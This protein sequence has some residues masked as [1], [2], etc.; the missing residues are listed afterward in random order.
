MKL[1]QDKRRLV[2]RRQLLTGAAATAV[3]AP[4]VPL[5]EGEAQEAGT[6][7]L[8]TWYTPNGTIHREWTPTGSAQNFTLGRILEPLEEMK[9]KIVVVSGLRHNGSKPGTNHFMGP[10]L[11][12]SGSTLNELSSRVYWGKSMSIDQAYAQHVGEVTPFSSLV[13]GV[14]SRQGDVRDRTSYLGENQPVTPQLD[15]GKVF[16]E[17]F[18]LVASDPGA[19]ETLRAQK[20]SVIDLVSA[21]LNALK[22]KFGSQ[23]SVKLDAHLESVRAI[24]RRLVAPSLQCNLLSEETRPNISAAGDFVATGEAMLDL[25]AAAFAC[26][27]TRSASMMWSGSTDNTQFSWAGVQ[28]LHHQLSHRDAEEAVQ[29]DLILINNWFSQQLAAFM[30]RLAAVSEG[31]GTLLDNTLVLAGNELGVGSAHLQTDIPYVVAGGA[32]GKLQMGRHVIAPSGEVSNRL[33]VSV[34]HALGM[35]DVTTFGSADIGTGP[36]AGL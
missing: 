29:E 17:L 8:L 11:T 19:L 24:E 14:S 30:S 12:F 3:L 10:S 35:D 20:Q 36:L 16:D 15:P 1:L 26:D 32:A 31:D 13:V 27:L 4:F 23:D 6:Q 34:Q 22:P 18:G 5:R 9:S 25:L 28:G 21:D 33:L 2:S 7:R